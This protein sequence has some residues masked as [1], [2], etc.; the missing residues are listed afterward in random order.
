MK[1]AK[2]MEEALKVNT[3]LTKI[4]L[5]YNEIDDEGAKAIEEALQV[6]A[7]CECIY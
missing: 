7:S 1:G 2:A 6:N 3:L 5:P 4:Y